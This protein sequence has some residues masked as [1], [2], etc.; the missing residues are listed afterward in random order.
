M[1]RRSFLKSVGKTIWGVLG[2][3]ALAL[4]SKD[5]RSSVVEQMV[6]NKSI[7]H[8]LFTNAC[9]PKWANVDT[10][11]E[12]SFV[13]FRQRQYLRERYIYWGNDPD[14]WASYFH[15]RG[16]GY[17]MVLRNYYSKEMGKWLCPANGFLPVSD[18]FVSAMI[19]HQAKMEST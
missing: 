14:N 3:V 1:N 13:Y 5:I 8:T 12:D 10:N 17:V 11:L 18:E 2:V 15:K 7:S 16:E 9:D 19:E 6:N 4:P